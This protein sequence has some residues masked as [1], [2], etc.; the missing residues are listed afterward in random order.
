MHL[1]L[2]LAMTLAMVLAAQ[3]K[4]KYPANV[5]SLNSLATHCL[6]CHTAVGMQIREACQDF[7]QGWGLSRMSI[8][9][10]LAEGGEP[11]AL[12]SLR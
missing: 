1:C 7:K 10:R 2:L 12:A 6:L 3:N 9:Q 8:A 4:T 5:S 11:V